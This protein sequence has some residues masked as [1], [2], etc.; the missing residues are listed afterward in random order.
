VRL[1][2]L[3]AGSS[4]QKAQGTKGATLAPKG[5]SCQVIALKLS[6]RLIQTGASVKI[7]QSPCFIG[8]LQHPQ[9]PGANPNLVSHRSGRERGE[10]EVSEGA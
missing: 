1:E 9:H 3:N 2:K 8:H 5:A 10:K 4:P 6:A 7:C